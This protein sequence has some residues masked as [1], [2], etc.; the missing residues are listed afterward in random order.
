MAKNQKVRGIK[1]TVG[2]K[3]LGTFDLGKIPSD[4]ERMYALLSAMP[5]VYQ[6]GTIAEI[7]GEEL[8][9]TFRAERTFAFHGILDHLFIVT[10]PVSLGTLK[11][12]G[13]IQKLKSNL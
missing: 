13:F 1:I 9:Y 11:S 10:I 5:I 6:K 4:K 12:L 3:S 2:D 8:T 7:K